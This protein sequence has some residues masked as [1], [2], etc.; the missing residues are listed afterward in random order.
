MSG[1]TE[2]QI[3][4][5]AE[6]FSQI[7]NKS[8]EIPGQARFTTT[9]ADD[10]QNFPESKGLAHGT[11]NRFRLGHRNA[12]VAAHASEDLM[13]DEENKRLLKSGTRKLDWGGYGNIFR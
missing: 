1:A 10:E 6:K 3:D 5:K 4:E 8:Y 9:D 13:I 12:D 11:P 2:C 7:S